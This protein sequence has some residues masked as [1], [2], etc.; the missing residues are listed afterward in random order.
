[1]WRKPI[2]EAGADALED[3]AVMESGEHDDTPE[4][5]DERVQP[6]YGHF[7]RSGF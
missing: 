6:G 5:E 2:E 1:M 3:E 4:D 7:D